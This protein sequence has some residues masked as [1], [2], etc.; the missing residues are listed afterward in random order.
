MDREK[1]GDMYM[2]HDLSRQAAYA[3]NENTSIKAQSC[4]H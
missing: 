1:D 2:S 3:L 4:F